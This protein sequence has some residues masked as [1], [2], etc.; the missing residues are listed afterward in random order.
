MITVDD[1][2]SAFRLTE[3]QDLVPIFGRTKGAISTW[4]QKGVPA[5]IERKAYALLEEKGIPVPSSWR[6]L[7]TQEEAMLDEE[8]ADLSPDE[9]LEVTL[10]LRKWKR[11]K[12]KSS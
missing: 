11:E 2:K 5:S 10:M 12:R 3:D 4:R 1:I 8:C 9:R 6:K 7:Q